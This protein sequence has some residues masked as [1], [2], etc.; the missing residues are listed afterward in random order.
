MDKRWNGLPGARSAV[1]SVSSALTFD[2]C[3]ESG[4][5]EL[6]HQTLEGRRGTR[7]G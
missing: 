3:E 4:H 6:A 7:F 5:E 2:H 1:G